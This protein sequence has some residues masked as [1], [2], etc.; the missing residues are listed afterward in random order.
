MRILWFTNDPLPAPLRRLRQPTGGTGH[1]LPSLLE[2]LQRCPGLEIEAASACRGVPDDDYT[3]NGVRYFT[4]GQPRF[5]PYFRSRKKDLEKC[6]AL[7]HERRPDLIHIH[8][9]ERFYGLMVTRGMVSTPCVISLQGLLGR[10]LASY[11]GAMQFGEIARA[12]RFVEVAT[13]RGI[14]WRYRDFAEGARIEQEILSGCPAFMGRTAWDRA[15]LRAVN[16]DAAYF[17]VGEILRA[18]FA[19]ARW[20][21]A[22]CDRYTVTFTNCGDPIRGAETL[23]DAMAIVRRQVPAARLRLAG[24]LGTRTGYHRLLRRRIAKSGLW[25][26]VDLLGYLDDESLANVLARSHVFATASFLENSPNSLCEAMQVG[27]PCVASFT[28]GIPS[29]VRDGESGLL[30]PCGD[31]ALLADAILRIFR[32]D[33]LAMRLGAQAR[34]EASHRHLPAHVMRQL[35]QA[36]SAVSKREIHAD[37]LQ[38]VSSR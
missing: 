35:L 11:F 3:E 27:T 7:V 23:F 13:R 31:P 32:D 28:G 9:T 14:L 36:Y 2:H 19:A 17:H 18:R 24:Y 21:L 29:L 22:N 15:Q 26:A 33:Q 37:H 12:D 30:F 4:F 20:D 25:D 6:A 5:L 1:W 16:P 10:Y 34:S 8:G 38:P